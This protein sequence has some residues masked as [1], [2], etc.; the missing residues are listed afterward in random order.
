MRVSETRDEEAWV[1]LL[2]ELWDREIS[3]HS[4]VE[5]VVCDGDLAIEGAVEIACPGVKSQQCIWH[6][7]ERSGGFGEAIPGREKWGA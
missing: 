3:P 2:D 6:Y 1:T 7:Q 4:G 5:W